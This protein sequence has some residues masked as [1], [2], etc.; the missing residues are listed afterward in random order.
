MLRYL[1]IE[2]AKSRPM[3][4]ALLIYVYVRIIIITITYI[5]CSCIVF[6]LMLAY[7]ILPLY[8]ENM[9]LIK[10]KARSKEKKKEGNRQLKKFNKRKSSKF[11]I[12]FTSSA[13]VLHI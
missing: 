13:L 11:Y 12:K 2:I 6:A 4:K 1:K 8:R 7:V 5:Y 10:K 3:K 9:L